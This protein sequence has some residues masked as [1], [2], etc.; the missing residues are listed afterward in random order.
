MRTTV[1]EELQ[2][3]KEQLQQQAV[4]PTVAGIRDGPPLKIDLF[5][6]PSGAGLGGQ[7]PRT[8]I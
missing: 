7:F 1:D 8:R 6:N 5:G 3:Q 4:I 2:Q